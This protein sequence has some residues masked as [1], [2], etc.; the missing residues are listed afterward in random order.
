M[1]NFFALGDHFQVIAGDDTQCNNQNQIYH[2]GRTDGDHSG[3][4]LPQVAFAKEAAG[5]AEAGPAGNAHN[6]GGKGRLEE[7]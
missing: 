6:G 1:G 5:Q 3:Q 2:H 7:G 4:S